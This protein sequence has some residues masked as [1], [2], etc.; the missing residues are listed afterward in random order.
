MPNLFHKFK[1]INQPVLIRDTDT[2]VYLYGVLI[3][4]EKI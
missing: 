4:V 1:H 3:K 2:F